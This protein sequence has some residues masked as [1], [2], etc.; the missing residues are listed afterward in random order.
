MGE[1]GP[2]GSIG[3]S[4]APDDGTDPW[5]LVRKADEAMYYVKN[6]IRSSFV[7]HSSLTRQAGPGP[8]DV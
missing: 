5:E 2:G 7:F 6:H 1:Q 3:I 8:H 4:L